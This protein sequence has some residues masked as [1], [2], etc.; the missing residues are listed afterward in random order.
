MITAAL[1]IA[2]ALSHPTFANNWFM[3]ATIRRPG[4]WSVT[5][6]PSHYEVELDAGYYTAD[7]QLTKEGAMEAGRIVRT[8]RTVRIDAPALFRQHLQ[9][10]PVD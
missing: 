8:L 10:V 7:G 5:Q 6:C 2:L 4:V 9:A 3:D 1:G